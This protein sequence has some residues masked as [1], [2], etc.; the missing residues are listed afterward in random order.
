MEYF[1]YGFSEAKRIID[2]IMSMENR[3]NKLA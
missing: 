3:I 1:L 2:Q